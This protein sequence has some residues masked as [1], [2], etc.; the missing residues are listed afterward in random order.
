MSVEEFLDSF[1]N[2]KFN[3]MT[4]DGLQICVMGEKKAFFITIH[5]RLPMGESKM[6]PACE[7]SGMMKEDFNEQ[8]WK[9]NK[10]AGMMPDLR[11]CLRFI[12]LEEENEEL[13]EESFCKTMTVPVFKV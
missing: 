5:P 9:K 10:Y 13:C 11:T 4:E 8:N 3:V 6:I 1:E 7:I 2:S 12:K